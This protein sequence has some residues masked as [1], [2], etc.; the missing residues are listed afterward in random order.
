LEEIILFTPGEISLLELPNRLVLSAT[1]ERM[2]NDLGLPLPT[3]I[4]LYR[5]LAQRGIGLIITGHMY[6]NPGGKQRKGNLL[7]IF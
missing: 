3:I 2:A 7:K 1:A 6:I 4:T 5:S